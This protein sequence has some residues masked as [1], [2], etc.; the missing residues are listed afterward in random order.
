VAAL[1]SC[2]SLT[3]AEAWDAVAICVKNEN[4]KVYSSAC[5]DLPHEIAHVLL[6]L[7]SL[8]AM[9]RLRSRTVQS[10]A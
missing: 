7:N 2:T 3:Y 8:L 10:L 5:A 1:N 4:L 9:L 6:L